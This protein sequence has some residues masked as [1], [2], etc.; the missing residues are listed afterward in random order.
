[1]FFQ[2]F[3]NVLGVLAFLPFLKI[4]E[5]FLQQRFRDDEVGS[6]YIRLVSPSEGDLALDAMDKEIKRF[7][8]CTV[9]LHLH[10]FNISDGHT[11]ST[12]I[13][14]FHKKGFSEKYE[15]LKLLH[16]EIHSYYI[17]MNKDLLDSNERERAEQLIS[18]VRNS[19]FSAKSIKD[20]FADIEQLK[21]SSS[22][23]KFA[24]YQ[25]T[26]LEVKE[27]SGLVMKHLSSEKSTSLYEEIITLY[28]RIQQGY[29]SELNKLYRQEL[30]QQL[31]EVD[32]STLINFNREF[33]ASYK[34]LVWAVKEYVLEKE[35]AD[36]FEELPGFIR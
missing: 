15:Y 29:Q 35:S 6:Y 28:N 25:R 18:A 10:A 12:E 36:Y 32:I 7:L 11:P 26:Q 27:F 31:T 17:A 16:G 21:N 4:F 13:E 34:A 14:T 22:S 3:I 20:S 2:S 5:N 23:T 1:V 19:M 8:G 33:F 24:V 30:N 9:D